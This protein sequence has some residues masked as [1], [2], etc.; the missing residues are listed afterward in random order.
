MAERDNF[1]VYDKLKAYMDELWERRNVTRK[2]IADKLKE[3]RTMGDLSENP[4]YD[5]VREEMRANEDRIEE[6]EK[7]IKK[8]KK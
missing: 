6:L 2:E 5:E 8:F 1:M 7:I 4:R 3:A